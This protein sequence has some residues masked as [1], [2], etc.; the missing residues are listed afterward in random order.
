MSPQNGYRCPK[1]GKGLSHIIEYGKAQLTESEHDLY[2]LYCFLERKWI[3]KPS[4]FDEIDLETKMGLLAI[5]QLEG[6][7]AEKEE[8]RMKAKEALAGL[9]TRSGL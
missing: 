2:L 9:K 1:L 8:G 4:D 3:S 5:L 7:K 6:K